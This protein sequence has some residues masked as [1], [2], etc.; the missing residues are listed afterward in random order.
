MKASG[1]IKALNLRQQKFVYENVEDIQ[2]VYKEHES[3]R[4]L[5]AI[6]GGGIFVLLCFIGCVIYY[7]FRQIKFNEN[8]SKIIDLQTKD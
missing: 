6:V 2:I 1:D 8:V 7:I 5:T 4:F 3:A